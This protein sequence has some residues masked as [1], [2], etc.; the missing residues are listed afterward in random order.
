MSDPD[1]GGEA[2]LITQAT[3]RTRTHTERLGDVTTGDFEQVRVTTGTVAV[4]ETVTVAHC[5][6]PLAP[7]LFLTHL[8]CV[9]CVLSHSSIFI[10]NKIHSFSFSPSSYTSYSH[11]IIK[12]NNNNNDNFS[13]F[14]FTKAYMQTC[15]GLVAVVGRQGHLAFIPPFSFWDSFASSFAASGSQWPA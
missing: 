8:S 5:L 9:L 2:H 13:F 7:S 1:W 14:P 6:L 4:P 15:L 3:R 10:H 11:L 12:E